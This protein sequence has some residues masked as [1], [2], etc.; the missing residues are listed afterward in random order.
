M[1]VAI[2]EGIGAYVALARGSNRNLVAERDSA[3]WVNGYIR[4]ALRSVAA[5][6]DRLWMQGAYYGPAAPWSDGFPVRKI[7]R[8]ASPA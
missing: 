3:N 8:C 2:K 6:S 5:G 1:T 7:T 4:L